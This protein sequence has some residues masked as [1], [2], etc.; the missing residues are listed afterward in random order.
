MIFPHAAVGHRPFGLIGD[1]ASGRR[2]SENG[3]SL[4]LC[5]LSRCAP[6]ANPGYTSACQTVLHRYEELR[7]TSYQRVHNMRQLCLCHLRPCALC[8]L[9]TIVKIIGTLQ[10]KSSDNDREHN[11]GNYQGNM[12]ENNR[13]ILPKIQWKKIRKRQGNNHEI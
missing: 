12:C 6:T 13:E 8:S 11:T 2:S 4:Q 7:S 10:G 1:T 9:R 5:G 3:P